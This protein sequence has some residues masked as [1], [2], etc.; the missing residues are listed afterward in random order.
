MLNYHCIRAM[1]S[2]KVKNCLYKINEKS[3]KNS[4]KCAKTPHIHWKVMVISMDND[5]KNQELNTKLLNIE[6]IISFCMKK[7]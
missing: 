6:Q 5:R 2:Q 7:L 1:S 4:K 3:R